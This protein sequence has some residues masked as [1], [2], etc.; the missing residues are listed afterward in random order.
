MMRAAKF[1]WRL[2][3]GACL[4]SVA[5]VGLGS[6]PAAAAEA[7]AS[8]PSLIA[9][10]HLHDKAAEAYKRDA[11]TEAIELWREALRLKPSWKYAYNLA[12][13]LFE[14]GQPLQAHEFV[15]RTEALGIPAQFRANLGLLKARVREDLHVDG[16]A[17][18]LLTVEPA[19]ARVTRD[20]QPWTSR[21]P[22]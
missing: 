5:M 2:G 4:V 3:L 9:A 13:T 10:E 17:W 22:R 11:K 6:V 12:N 1:S 8:D 18:L 15:Q 19:D 21:S 16:Y 7:P 20:G 14:T